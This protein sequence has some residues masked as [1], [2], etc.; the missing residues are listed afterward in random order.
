MLYFRV[1]DENTGNEYGFEVKFEDIAEYYEFMGKMDQQS[2]LLDQI[3]VKFGCHEM[4]GDDEYTVGFSTREVEDFEGCI[5]YWKEFFR[6]SG[7]LV[8]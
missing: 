7:Y 4:V 2:L 1:I 6:Q 8:E 5:D 3:N